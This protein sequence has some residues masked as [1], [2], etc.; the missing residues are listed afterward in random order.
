MCK[1]NK[2]NHLE[3]EVQNTLANIEL[4]KDTKNI[5]KRVWVRD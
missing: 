1:Q 3:D 4:L 5:K 2:I